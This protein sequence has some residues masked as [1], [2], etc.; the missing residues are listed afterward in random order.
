MFYHT[1]NI[2]CWLDEFRVYYFTYT[3]CTFCYVLLTLNFRYS[4]SDFF[5]QKRMFY[6]GAFFLDICVR[7]CSRYEP[8]SLSTAKI[9]TIIKIY[10]SL[11]TIFLL[12][13]SKKVPFYGNF[14]PFFIRNLF[15]L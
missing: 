14:N 5:Y 11:G 7:W 4:G 12:G 9:I 3:Q 10:I 2:S 1:Y 8:Y 13:Y 15:A 6:E